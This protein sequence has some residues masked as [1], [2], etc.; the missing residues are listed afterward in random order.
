M[1]LPQ[2]F[3]TLGPSTLN[4][5]F[6]SQIGNR[7]DLLRLNL[8]HMT[9][10]EMLDAVFFIRSH[11][12]VPICIDT[13][14]AQIRTQVDSVRHYTAGDSVVLTAP[15]LTPHTVWTQLSVGDHLV[16]GFNGLEIKI[17]DH[18]EQRITAQCVR[19]GPLETH[20][21]VHCVGST[22]QLPTLSD[23]DLVAIQR[24]QQIGIN[25]FA[26]SFTQ[27]HQ[28]MQQFQ[29]L[30]PN[31]RLIYKIETRSALADLAE[32]FQI[33]Q[34][35][36]IDRGDLGKDIGAEQVPLAQRQIMQIKQTMPQCRVYVATNFLE[37]MIEKSEATRA[38]ISDIYTALEQGA[39]G[40]VLAA[41]TAIGHY[42]LDCVAQIERVIQ[43]YQQHSKQQQ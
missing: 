15:E 34:E 38:E 20:K 4:A 18:D 13:E 17:L 10:A 22:V 7:V 2:I 23:K 11:S 31:S 1:T 19:S 32:M 43:V 5:S 35:F 24:A 3:V 39:D 40:L 26:L 28:A 27:N 16:I 14:G 21:G 6:L 25:T 9:V 41:E 8:S 42:P 37:T 30:L 29:T 36:L 12:A 33:G